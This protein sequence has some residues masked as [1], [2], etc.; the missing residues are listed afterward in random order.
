MVCITGGMFVPSV[1]GPIARVRAQEKVIYRC[2][3]S[4][5]PTLVRQSRGP[6]WPAVM[7]VLAVY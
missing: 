7:T 1:D 2:E 5:V 6:Q 3:L 4:A